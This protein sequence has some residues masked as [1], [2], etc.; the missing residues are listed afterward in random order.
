MRSLDAVY[1]SSRYKNGKCGRG[2]VPRER[3]PSL[4]HKSDTPKP[5]L[6]LN[7]Y[8]KSWLESLGEGEKRSL[9]AKESLNLEL[10]EEVKQSVN[11]SIDAYCLTISQ[12]RGSISTPEGLFTQH[13]PPRKCGLIGQLITATQLQLPELRGSLRQCNCL[14][15][16]FLRTRSRHQLR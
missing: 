8:N 16:C 14:R 5:G 10:P 15:A 4:R 13:R 7:F 3:Y 11:P 12:D 1:L 2:S 9:G 6:P